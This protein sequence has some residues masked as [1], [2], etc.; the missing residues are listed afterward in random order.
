MKIIKLKD[1]PQYEKRMD[2]GYFRLFNNYPEAYLIVCDKPSIVKAHAPKLAYAMNG[3]DLVDE[4]PEIYEFCFI[5][6]GRLKALTVG[7]VRC[8]DYE[9]VSIFTKGY[10]E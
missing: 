10:E 4:N 9:L 3:R 6:K 8:V 7:E 5:V 1:I 2:G